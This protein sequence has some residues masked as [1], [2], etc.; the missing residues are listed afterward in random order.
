LP[1]LH[2]ILFYFSSSYLLILFIQNDLWEFVR[3]GQIICL[4]LI[5]R[6]LNGTESSSTAYRLIFG[7][8]VNIKFCFE[9]QFSNPIKLNRL[10]SG[11]QTAFLAVTKLPF[12]SDPLTE[13]TSF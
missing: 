5:D 8:V 9:N 3:G 2:F 10:L 11:N 1:R 7:S 6:F 13:T 4:S 12:Y